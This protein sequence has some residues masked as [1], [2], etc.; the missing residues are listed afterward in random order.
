MT[1]PAP[2]PIDYLPPDVVPVIVHMHRLLA[3]LRND[4]ASKDKGDEY[5]GYILAN[6]KICVE[7]VFSLSEAAN[8]VLREMARLP[9][10]PPHKPV[11]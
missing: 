10:L 9:A 5:A 6:E 11:S 2:S 7:Y 8:D 1:T 3:A 4:P